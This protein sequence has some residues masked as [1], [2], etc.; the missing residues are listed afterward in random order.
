VRRPNKLGPQSLPPKGL[1]KQRQREATTAQNARDRANNS[2]RKASSSSDKKNTKRRGV[3]G[4]ATQVEAV[5]VPPP[6]KTTTR[7]R[8]INRPAGYK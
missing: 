6:P 5:Q 7:G 2:K 4:A 1:E 3:V 8:P